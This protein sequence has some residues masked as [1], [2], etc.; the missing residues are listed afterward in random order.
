VKNVKKIL[1]ESESADPSIHSKLCE[2]RETEKREKGP[3]Y[4]KEVG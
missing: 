4:D 2:K 3:R 1:S